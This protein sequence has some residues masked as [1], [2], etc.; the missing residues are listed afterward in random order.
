MYTENEDYYDENVFLKADRALSK[1]NFLSHLKWK[2]NLVTLRKC[3]SHLQC[4]KVDLRFSI[5]L[6]KIN[7]RVIF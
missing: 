6:Q 1:F 5:K 3:N 4:Y 7:L 2:I